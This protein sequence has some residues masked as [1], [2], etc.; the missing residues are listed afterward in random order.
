MTLRFDQKLY[1]DKI[2]S[3]KLYDFLGNFLNSNKN[4]NKITK[5]I[6]KYVVHI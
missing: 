6:A 1:V 2:L 3:G 5:L 4:N